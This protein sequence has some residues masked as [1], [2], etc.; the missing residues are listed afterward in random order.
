MDQLRIYHVTYMHVV[1]LLFGISLLLHFEQIRVDQKRNFEPFINHVIS[2][3]PTSGP[4]RS[5]GTK[6]EISN[7]LK[8]GLNRYS[9]TWSLIPK[10]I[11]G[12]LKANQHA[13]AEYDMRH[14]TKS[15]LD[16]KLV[17][18]RFDSWKLVS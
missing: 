11:S 2:L 13:Y 1:L 4:L 10:R 15:Q 18:L 6:S 17:Q 16:L 5:N 3:N 8:V 9:I 14:V 7:S 12:G